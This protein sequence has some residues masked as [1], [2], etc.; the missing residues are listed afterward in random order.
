LEDL[1][2]L[3]GT[4]RFLPLRP[5]VPKGSTR[6]FAKAEKRI[7]FMSSFLRAVER[8]ETFS[9]QMTPNVWTGSPCGYEAARDVTDALKKTGLIVVVREPKKRHNATI[10]RCSDSF[11]Q[12]LEAQHEPL[13]FKLAYNDIIEVREPKGDCFGRREKKARI[14]LSRFPREAIKAEQERLRRLN[15]YLSQY[16]FVDA[17]G[18]PVDTTLK[19]IFDGDLEHGGRLYGAYQVERERDRL[20]STLAGEPVCEIDFKASHVS[21]AAALLGHPGRLPQDPYWA[22]PWVH[23]ARDRKAAKLLVQCM[24]H[25]RD[26]RPSQFPKLD[27]GASFKRTYGF[28]GKRIGDLLVRTVDRDTVLSVLQ[29]TLKAHLGVHAPWLDVSAAGQEP[30][31]VE[32]LTYSIDQRGAE[33]PRIGPTTAQGL[34]GLSASSDEDDL[35][36]DGIVI[37]ED[38][39]W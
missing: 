3:A 28:E 25:A 9:I 31:L 22:I 11:A 10:Y 17:D 29:K 4:E 5:D 18:R 12:Q 21:I 24:V 20:K 8:N 16:P 36:E 35:W 13:A 19:R 27:D 7:I 37:E 26:G 32:P 6:I 30:Y 33:A 15:E 23:T 1:N 38:D 14:P 2:V 39:V 34:V